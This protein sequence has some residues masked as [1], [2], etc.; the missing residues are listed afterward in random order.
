MKSIK[1]RPWLGD[2]IL[3]RNRTVVGP[4]AGGAGATSC[5]AAVRGPEAEVCGQGVL[6]GNVAAL[7]EENGRPTQEGRRGH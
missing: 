5:R 2:Q 4:L 7:E 6:D 3:D 1:R